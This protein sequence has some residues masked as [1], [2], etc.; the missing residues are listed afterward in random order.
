MADVAYMFHFPPSE[1]W[2]MDM[3]DL[4]MWHEEALRI[5]DATQA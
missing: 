1:L 4:L 2:M 5:H 3:D